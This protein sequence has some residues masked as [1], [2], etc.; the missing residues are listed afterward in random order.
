MTSFSTIRAESLGHMDPNQG[1]IIDVRT[2]M[3][4]EE[5]HIGFGHAH[6][7]LDEL[8]PT[9]FMMRHGLDRDADVYILCRSGKRA[10]Q[11]AEKF[12]AEGYRKVKV[13]EGGI[14]AVEEFGH[15]VKGH[16]AENSTS[17]AKV[18]GP[19]SLER[20]VRIAAGLFAATG[21]ALGLLISP[22]FTVIP[23]FVGC[24]LIFA[25]VTDRCGMALVLTKAPWNKTSSNATCAATSCSSSVKA[26][27]P[28]GAKIG[29]SCQ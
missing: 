22:V 2:K 29:Q 20:Q 24:G 10:A 26:G 5:K 6:V 27:T 3:E 18:K 14:I 12:A 1:I 15:D 13:I 28:A 25:G 8:K 23:L 17:G 21:A 9:D 4:H 11:A 7:P 16:G 19:I